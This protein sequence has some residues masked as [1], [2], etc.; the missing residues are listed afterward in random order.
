MKKLLIN[1]R[2]VKYAK[3]RS[4][5]KTK[6]ASKEIAGYAPTTPSVKIENSL[7]MK[8]LSVRDSLLSHISLQDI[9]KAHAEV[10]NQKGDLGARNTAIKLAYER[11]EPDTISNEETDKITVVLKG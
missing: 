2:V 6:K 4:E 5:G 10:I 3:A 7:A 9:T 11:I 8:S 1:D